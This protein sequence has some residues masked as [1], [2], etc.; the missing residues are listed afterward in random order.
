VSSEILIPVYNESKEFLCNMRVEDLDRQ[1]RF[2]VIRNRR[3]HAKRAYVRPTSCRTAPLLP[4]G[5]SQSFAQDVGGGVYV[6]ALKGVHGS[7]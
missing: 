3:G 4:G 7:A 2:T 1:Q 5:S 6:W